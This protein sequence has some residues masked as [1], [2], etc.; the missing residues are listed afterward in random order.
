M[1]RA[2]HLRPG[3]GNADP[4]K[5]SDERQQR[6]HTDD[7]MLVLHAGRPLVFDSAVRSRYTSDGDSC[8][9]ATYHFSEAG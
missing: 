1:Q 2:L 7:A 9:V 3:N 5:V 6:Q 8:E 4:I